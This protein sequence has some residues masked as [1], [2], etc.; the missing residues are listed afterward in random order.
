MLK[1]LSYHNVLAHLTNP[2]QSK[3]THEKNNSRKESHKNFQLYLLFS[4][5]I[6]R[7]SRK[8]VAQ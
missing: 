7:K 2:K 5:P 8:Y 4:A 6:L 1:H 3:I